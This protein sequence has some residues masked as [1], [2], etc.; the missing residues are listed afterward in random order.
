MK[1]VWRNLR[2]RQVD[3][4]S[5]LPPVC[6]DTYNFGHACSM[7]VFEPC[8][9][10][11]AK[12]GPSTQGRV[13]MQRFLTSLLSAAVLVH[14]TMG[15]CVHHAHSD[16]TNRGVT[17]VD[18]AMHQKCCGHAAHGNCGMPEGSAERCPADRSAP[19]RPHHSPH[20]CSGVK[21]SFLLG[22]SSSDSEPV[23][24]GVTCHAVCL[25][26]QAMAVEV[27]AKTHSARHAPAPLPGS[28]RRHLVLAVLLV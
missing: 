15:C 23:H 24:T 7:A 11:G 8:R 2:H 4:V 26:P 16:E 5:A 18:D 17:A 22:K 25:P 10:A 27:H 9:M 6:R 20:G 13:L 21:C 14:A 1:D 3:V 12:N 28:L 19:A